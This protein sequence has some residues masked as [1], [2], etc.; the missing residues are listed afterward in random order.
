MIRHRPFKNA[1][2]NPEPPKRDFQDYV[3]IFFSVLWFHHKA[4][5]G[6]ILLTAVGIW[7]YR[8]AITPREIGFSRKD[9]LSNRT[10]PDDVP[11]ANIE[12]GKPNRP[13]QNDDTASDTDAKPLAVDKIDEG[14]SSPTDGKDNPPDD[15]D[16][17]DS[18]EPNSVGEKRSRLLEQGTID[19][20]IKESLRIYDIWGRSSPGVGVVLCSE[21]AKI[22]RRLLE[23]ELSD[24]QRAFALTSYIESISLVDSLN[25]SSKM[26][27]EGTREALLEIDEKY[28][29]HPD[30]TINSKANLA[31]TLA[32]LYDFMATGELEHLRNFQDQFA[33]RLPKIA[34]DRASLARLADVTIAMNNK[35]GLGH[36]R[37]PVVQEFA[38][39][40]D[41][42]QT[43]SAK[44]V[45]N[46]FRMRFLYDKFDPATIGIAATVNDPENQ[47]RV[48]SFF[49]TLAA[50]PQSDEMIYDAAIRAVVAYQSIGKLSEADR[51]LKLL[52]EASEKIPDEEYRQTIK[53]AISAMKTQ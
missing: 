34:T 22:S 43:P 33:R 50:N 17:T 18:N 19:E 51:L 11:S 1:E 21:R 32:P 28:S 9:N 46:S 5:I 24:A 10:R 48:R 15:S 20:L 41:D 6:L 39:R 42:L 14:S 45:A 3:E 38:D 16:E 2:V 27:L 44:V 49:K 12:F 53:N 40:L 23:M 29:N 8:V 35:P 37:I 47:Q 36:T 26:N 4:I 7:I 30:P 25:V 52:H 13:V 31:M